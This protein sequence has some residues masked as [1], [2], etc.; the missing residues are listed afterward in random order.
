MIQ[1]LPGERTC[2]GCVAA[3]ITGT[4]LQAVYDF[5][6]G[7]ETPFPTA[8]IFA[9]FGSHG[10]IPG[11]HVNGLIR[12]GGGYKLDVSANMPAF[13]V[14]DVPG[15]ESSHA[16]FWD[17]TRVWDPHNAEATDNLEDFTIVSWTPLYLP[18]GESAKYAGEKPTAKRW[19]VIGSTLYCTG[20]DRP[21]PDHSRHPGAPCALTVVKSDTQVEAVKQNKVTALILPEIQEA[22]SLGRFTVESAF[23]YADILAE[24]ESEKAKIYQ[25]AA[26]VDE[27]NRSG[28]PQ[29]AADGVH[30]KDG[31]AAP[32]RRD[33]I[34]CIDKLNANIEQ[35]RKLAS[36]RS[37]K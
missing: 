25:C 11:Y 13:V 19:E 36:T 32:L 22:S 37:S 8:R 3:M 9:F 17:G 2:S 16:V 30:Y 4:T 14:V 15:Q 26:V 1:Q 5:M 31:S 24:I 7:R 10:I 18:I 6:G 23:S 34:A 20:G 35:L 29:A 12:D 27:Y 33:A 28:D 21:R